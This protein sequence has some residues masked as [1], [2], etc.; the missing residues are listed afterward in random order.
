MLTIL[1]IVAVILTGLMAGFFFAYWCS[2]MIGLRSVRDETFVETMQHINAVLPNAMFAPPFVG[3]LVVPAIAAWIAF[4][5]GA[6]TTGWWLVASFVLY[7]ATFAI[8]AGRNVPMNN[9]LATAGTPQDAAD[10]AEIRGDFEE[11]WITWNT[12]RTA[13]NAASFAAAVVA[14]AV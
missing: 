3:A 9:A 10:A 4:R 12:I 7:L 13:T 5:D 6:N 2:V 1:M 8:T 14:L 11:P